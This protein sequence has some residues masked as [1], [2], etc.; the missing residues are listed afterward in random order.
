MLRETYDIPP[1]VGLLRPAPEDRPSRPRNGFAT[2]TIG[3]LICGMRL[4]FSPIAQRILTRLGVHACQMSPAFYHMLAKG[5]M[6]W[7]CQTQR[8]M[9][10]DDFRNLVT[11]FPASGQPGFHMA[12]ARGN[13]RLV[14]D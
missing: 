3:N 9:T 13:V 8:A 2:V 14:D 1:L 5:F 4:P 10:M 7:H 11:V 12:R 6:E